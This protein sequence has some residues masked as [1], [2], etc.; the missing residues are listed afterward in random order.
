MGAILVYHIPTDSVPIVSGKP[1][2]SM[3]AHVSAVRVLLMLQTQATVESLRVGQFLVD[4]NFRKSAV[5]MEV[6]GSKEGSNEMENS[7]GSLAREDDENTQFRRRSASDPVTIRREPDKFHPRTHTALSGDRPTLKVTRKAASTA[8]VGVA[9]GRVVRG[10]EPA[11][12]TATTEMGGDSK[13]VDGAVSI[14]ERSMTPILP[15]PLTILQES[16]EVR[17]TAEGMGPPPPEGVWSPSEEA[18]V[19]EDYESDEVENKLRFQGG[20]SSASLGNGDKDD[21]INIQLLPKSQC[22]LVDSGDYALPN[23]L[24][25]EDEDPYSVPSELDNVTF[26]KKEAMAAARAADEDEGEGDDEGG[27]VETMKRLST[28]EM[29]RK[30]ESPYDFP[31]ELMG[32][33]HDGDV[34]PYEDPAT[35]E[36]GVS[37]DC[38]VTVAL[39]PG[40]HL[41]LPFC[42]H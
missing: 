42:A 13:E 22:S 1:Y 4:E 38:H 20:I 35:L 23:E 19:L 15:D 14:L 25:K 3:E 11:A 2:L 6:E 17:S 18:T 21:I 37:C 27:D 41:K 5:E 31:A 36:K 16:T 9:V 8:G 33:R 26:R 32:R 40:S 10:N 28:L 7:G 34:N 39:F 30:M 29:Q 12:N 24:D